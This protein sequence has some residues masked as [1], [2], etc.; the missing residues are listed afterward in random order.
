MLFTYHLWAPAIILPVCV[1]V[2]SRTRGPTLSRNILITMVVSVIAT[3]VYRLSPYRA[4]VDPSVFGVAVS[5]VTFGLLRIV[6]KETAQP[7]G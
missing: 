3:M 5:L 2:F 4:Q 6:T 1:G 7:A